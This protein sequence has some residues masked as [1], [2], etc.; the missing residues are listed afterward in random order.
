MFWRKFCF[1]L[2]FVRFGLF[3]FFGLVNPGRNCGDHHQSMFLLST[4]TFLSYFLSLSSFFL[5]F[6]SVLLSSYSRSFLSHF[7]SFF[8]P[9]SYFSSF[10][11]H[12]WKSNS[13]SCF[14]MCLNHYLLFSYI[15][16]SQFS[17]FVS[18]IAFFSHTYFLSLLPP[19]FT[20]QKNHSLL[21]SL[22]SLSLPTS[23]FMCA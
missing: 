17:F 6:L 20:S 10:L 7:L 8:P 18:S 4:A 5:S 2:I 16:M 15:F 9:S 14:S 13:C 12:N 21:S 3:F 23:S 1:Y 22:F 19:F 11:I